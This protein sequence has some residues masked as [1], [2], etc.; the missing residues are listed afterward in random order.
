MPSEC[1]SATASHACSTYVTV[2]LTGSG[3]RAGEGLREVLAVEV[4]HDHVR[5]AGVERAD[6]EHARDV[7]AADLDRGAGLADEAL[8]DLGVGRDGRPQKLQRHPLVELLV[9]RGDDDRPCRPRRARGRRGTCPRPRRPPEWG[10]WMQRASRG[11]PFVLRQDRPPI[12]SSRA[13]PW[14]WAPNCP[15]RG[16]RRIGPEERQNEARRRPAEGLTSRASGFADERRS[17]QPSAR[18]SRRR[19]FVAKLVVKGAQ[20]MCSMGTSPAR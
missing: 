18:L 17:G 15:T 3:P 8:H 16:R 2:S 9:R 7:L 5:R 1:A 13:S 19:H 20:L 14:R 11:A 12:L 10:R 4:L 6:V